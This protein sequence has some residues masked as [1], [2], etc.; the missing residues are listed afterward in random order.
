[1]GRD[2]TKLCGWNEGR[3]GHEWWNSPPPPPSNILKM[4][5][6]REKKEGYIWFCHYKSFCWGVGV[7]V[8]Q[9]QPTT[10]TKKSQRIF[11]AVTLFLVVV[12]RDTDTLYTLHTIT[13]IQLSYWERYRLWQS[14]LHFFFVLVSLGDVLVP[15]HL[16]VF[17]TG[18]DRLYICLHATGQ[19]LG[20]QTV[21]KYLLKPILYI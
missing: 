8:R 6:H 20:L 16:V 18:Q 9:S 7:G 10:T 1:M 14:A 17:W 4:S 15:R 21:P 19:R 3:Y 12:I 5:K 13:K 2:W 11:A